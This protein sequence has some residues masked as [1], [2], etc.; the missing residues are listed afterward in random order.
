ME[1]SLLKKGLLNPAAYPDR[2]KKI[3]LIETYISLVFL[4]GKYA[5]KIT[6]AV[7]FGF[8][9][10]SSVEKRKFYCEEEVR[11]NRRLAPTLYLGVFPITDED[12][13]LSLGGS[14]KVIEYAVKMVQ[15]P[16]RFLMNHLLEKNRVG[17]KMMRAISDKLVEFYK[18][19]ET[20]PYIESFA[21]PQRLKQD[22]D[23]N[24]K[25]TKRF[26]GR[27]ISSKTYRSI[28][29]KTNGF[30][31][32]KEEIFYQRIN[33]HRIRDCHGDLRLEHIVWGKEIAVIDCIEFNERFRYTDIAAD[34]AFLTMD[35][36]YL[37]KPEL[38]EPFL[39]QYTKKSGDTDLVS[40]LDFYK[41]YRAYVRGKVDSF[42]SEDP[43]LSDKD[44]GRAFN[45][46]Q[47][48]FR[49]SYQYANRL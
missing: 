18:S 21:R 28:Q 38:N 45:S 48:Y 14:G 27:T 30:F 33:S 35:V 43:E 31:K 42:Q 15:I 44:K 10:F 7:D 20:S 5:Y 13:M 39:E 8:L 41:C 12:G 17:S 9:D 47:K 4:T 26:I 49:L 24:F 3:D 37:A 25:Q 11:L 2:P 1:L 32:E 16:G 36:D 19:A 29:E 34:L 6:R 23:E 46:A 22:T 40:V